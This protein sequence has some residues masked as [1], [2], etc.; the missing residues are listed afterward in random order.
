[1]IVKFRKITRFHLVVILAAKNDCRRQECGE[2]AEKANLV[3]V[4]EFVRNIK[5]GTHTHTQTAVKP[6]HLLPKHTMLNSRRINK[7][8]LFPAQSVKLFTTYLRFQGCPP[9]FRTATVWTTKT[10]FFN[11]LAVRGPSIFPKLPDLL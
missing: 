2:Q 9:P 8:D 10:S 7:C 5:F 4:G 3:K 1:M 6:P 11:S